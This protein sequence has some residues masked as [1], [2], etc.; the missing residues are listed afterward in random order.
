METR[1]TQYT[2]VDYC[3]MY[4]RKEVR[5]NRQY[6]RSDLVWPRTAQSFLVET[7]LLDF[8]VPKLFLHQQTDLR[9]RRPIKEIV[10][11]Q[12]RTRAIVDYFNDE[13]RLT[14][15]VSLEEAKGKRFSELSEELQKS[16]QRLRPPIR[17]LRRRHRRGRPG[18]VSENELF[19]CPS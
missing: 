2:V 6:Q 14:S 13:Y 12:Q 16:V 1:T 17:P 11:G 3:D 4:E 7:I 10:D 18:S 15:N 19:H 9:T 5:V 8:P